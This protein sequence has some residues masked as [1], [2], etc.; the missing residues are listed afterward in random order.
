MSQ[1]IKDLITAANATNCHCQ[2][3]L[4]IIAHKPSLDPSF[5]PLAGLLHAANHFMKVGHR[6]EIR[7]MISAQLYEFA[8]TDFA[9]ANALVNALGEHDD[10]KLQLDAVLL[11]VMMWRSRKQA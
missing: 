11:V 2:T 3:L 8:N 5:M 9:S 6:I 7:G 4:H 10:L 1:P